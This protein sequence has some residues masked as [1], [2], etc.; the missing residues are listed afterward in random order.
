MRSSERK[1]ERIGLLKSF[2]SQTAV[3]AHTFNSSTR[4]VEAIRSLEFKTSLV[5][6]EDSISVSTL[7]KETLSEKTTKQKKTKQ[8]MFENGSG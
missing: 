8:K 7:P 3:M 1:R 6:I 4:E 2:K 5:Y